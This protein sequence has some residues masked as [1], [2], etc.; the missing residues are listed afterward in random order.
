VDPRGY[1]TRIDFIA[2]GLVSAAAY[3]AI[4]G[5]VSGGVGYAECGAALVVP[6]LATAAAAI[7]DDLSGD[8]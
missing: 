7:G 2:G 3:C 8:D 4:G 5:V 1:H 6:S